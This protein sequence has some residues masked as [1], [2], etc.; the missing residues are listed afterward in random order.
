[1]RII[2]TLGASIPRYS[3]IC[4]SSVSLYFLL[5]LIKSSWS[6]RTI[7]AAS[8]IAGTGGANPAQPPWGGNS[9]AELPTVGYVPR[10]ELELK[11]RCIGKRGMGI[12]VE[13]GKQYRHCPPIESPWC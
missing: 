13:R 9:A 1:M 10:R 11:A 3:Y 2:V 5:K 7:S 6:K 8:S 12:G 4:E